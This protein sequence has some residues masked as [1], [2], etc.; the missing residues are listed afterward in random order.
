MAIENVQGR[1]AVARLSCIRFERSTS[2][3]A[4]ALAKWQSERASLLVPLTFDLATVSEDGG[5]R[6]YL[7]RARR[8]REAIAKRVGLDELQAQRLSFMQ[9]GRTAWYLGPRNGPSTQTPLAAIDAAPDKFIQL[10]LMKGLLERA[11]YDK[12]HVFITGAFGPGVYLGDAA[13]ADKRRL[14]LV[15][16]LFTVVLKRNHVICDIRSRAFAKKANSEETDAAT[17]LADAGQGFM[18]GTTRLSP[19]GYRSIDAREHPL[20]GVSLDTVRIRQ[21]RLYYLNLVTEFALKFFADAGIEAQCD[22][23]EATHCIVDGFVP[24]EPLAS[25]ARPLVV[26]SANGETITAESIRPLQDLPTYFPAGYHVAGNRKAHFKPVEVRIASESVSSCDAALNYLFLNGAPNE[27]ESSAALDGENVS[28]AAAYTALTEARGEVDLYTRVK[29]RQLLDRPT[30]DIVTQ[31]L[32][33]PP[34]SL[35]ALM[36]ASIKPDDRKLQEA[37]KRCL[38]ELSL[39]ECLVG[40]KDVPLPALPK[41]VQPLEVTLIAT[42]VQR[43]PARKQ[44]K[45]LVAIVDVQIKDGFARVGRVRR[46]PWS[47]DKAAVIDFVAEFPFLMRDGRDAI[48]DDQFWMVHRGSGDRL[49]VWTGAIVPRVLLNAGYASIEAALAAQAPY[50]SRLKAKGSR[51]RYYSKGR[52]Y[53]L[54]PYYMSFF[55]PAHQVRGERAGARIAVQDRGAFLRVFVPPD[56]GINGSGDA[57]SGMRDVMVFRAN[58]ELVDAALLEHQLVVMHLHTMTNGVLVGGENS[59][60]SVLE[61]LAKLALEN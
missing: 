47:S 40:A 7:E 27:G 6:D 41:S 45:Q 34:S 57:L 26:T 25:L 61:K 35:A 46:S 29:F 5:R 39:K 38:V 10:M 11:A 59:K 36:P 16:A 13:T 33:V 12:E 24:L 31:G 15:E 4:Q 30:F 14:Q 1:A 28:L 50:L 37:L 56:G 54:L 23:F 53:N 60:M 49:R 21:S 22:T 20:T 17:L 8:V 3:V 9:F 42:R 19:A 18:V 52:D 51:G 48:D 2:E 32:D 55:K 43:L 44:V 58:G